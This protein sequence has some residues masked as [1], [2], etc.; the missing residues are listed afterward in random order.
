[1]QVTDWR[2]RLGDGE[3]SLCFDVTSLSHTVSQPLQ[4]FL[5]LLAGRNVDESDDFIVQLRKRVAFVKQ[6]RKWRRE[7]MLRTVYEMEIEHDRRQAVKKGHE[8][9]ANDE[10]LNLVCDLIR[11]GQSADEVIKFLTTIRRMPTAEAEKY[12]QQ[13]VERLKKHGEGK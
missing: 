2:H 7:Y 10:R 9:V 6:N 11:S 12:Y 1:M 5:D 3:V 13:A 8:Q 4:N